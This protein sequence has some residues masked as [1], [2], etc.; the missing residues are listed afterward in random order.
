MVR[1]T[2]E[3]ADILAAHAPAFLRASGREVSAAKLR[4]LR[5]LIACRTLALGAH[6]QRCDLC[7]FE[8]VAYNSCRDRHCPKC[9]AAA[10]AEWLER[11]EARLLP[12]R[13]F[14][15]V[16]TIP[17]AM[18]EVALQNKK[19]LYAAL[20]RAAAQTLQ[21]IGRDPRHLGGRLG[22][23]SVLHTWGQNLRHHPHV[24]CVV[25]GGAL[26]EDRKSWISSRRDFFAPVRVLAKVFRGKFLAATRRAFA[27]GELQFQ[28]KL[29]HLREPR[30]FEQYL[31]S[32]RKTPWVVYA[33]KPFGGPKQVLRYL[34]RYTHR[35]AIS[36][37]RLIS[38][39]DGQVRFRWK[40]YRN[41][42]RWGVMVL[43]ALEFIRRFLLHVLP[44]GFQRIRHYG[45]LA[46]RS[47]D[48][49]RCQQLLGVHRPKPPTA[50]PETR[51]DGEGLRCP[52]CG[53]GRLRTELILSTQQLLMLGLPRT[54]HP[55]A[56]SALRIRSPPRPA[57]CRL[58]PLDR[59]GSGA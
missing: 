10:R 51:P 25:P 35:V 57:A 28:G 2:L 26:S 24:H 7:D 31:Q 43:S 20:M 14:H 33:K 22:F 38:L 8:R 21:R 9:Q 11:Q 48:F 37:H 36:N 32:T 55:S 52:K 3:V 49:E 18:A 5:R 46:N 40:D 44:T 16:F 58:H 56:I 6:V 45:F 15:V 27:R 54:A 1:P 19:V 23:L 59:H 30:A 50:D 39:K 13:Y 17:E 34:A 29:S 42:N 4:V 41:G 12:V 53:I 47:D